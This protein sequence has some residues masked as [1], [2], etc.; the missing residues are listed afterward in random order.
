MSDI[1]VSVGSNVI[2]E[3]V[4]VRAL[5]EHEKPMADIPESFSDDNDSYGVFLGHICVA[6]RK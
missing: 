4:L 5:V 6:V 1:V 3:Q 2:E